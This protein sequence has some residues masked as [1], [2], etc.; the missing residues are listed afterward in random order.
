MKQKWFWGTFLF[1]TIFTS[2]V[3]AWALIFSPVR[4]SPKTLQEFQ[5]KING[6][7]EKNQ[8]WV[9]EGHLKEL[10]PVIVEKWDKEGWKIHGQKMDLTPAVLGLLDDSIDLEDNLQVRVFKKG[11]LYRTLGLWE[12]PGNDETYGWV[13]ELPDRAFNPSL[14]VEKWDFP[15]APPPN[16]LRIYC[17]GLGNLKVALISLPPPRNFDD[18]F[19]AYCSSQGFTGKLWKKNEDESVY[20]LN[21]GGKKI[22]AFLNMDE[23][24]GHISLVSFD[25][26]NKY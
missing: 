7:E 5:T 15:M 26:K 18:Q 13:G 24:E 10:L 21:Q 22:L 25:P 9:N 8:I 23:G 1:L 17:Q 16:A 6:T 3:I 11:D 12:P 4:F 20:F 14:A 2:T 19:L